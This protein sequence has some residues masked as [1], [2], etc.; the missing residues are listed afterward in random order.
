MVKLRIS[1]LNLW[2]ALSNRNICAFYLI[3]IFLLTYKREGRLTFTLLY[4]S[5]LLVILFILLCSAI[6]SVFHLLSF[7]YY[8]SFSPS[9]VYL[10]RGSINKT[11]RRQFHHKHFYIIF[12]YACWYN[13]TTNAILNWMGFTELLVFTMNFYSPLIVNKKSLAPMARVM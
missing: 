5:V 10:L 3:F 6:R 9:L 8:I 13:L 2:I 7:S 1:A 4:Y 11:F 12:F